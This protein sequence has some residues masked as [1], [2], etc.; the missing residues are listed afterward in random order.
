[1][2]DKELN[3]E[4]Q[5]DEFKADGENSIVAD[6]TNVSPKKRKADKMMPGDKAT[7]KLADNT[8]GTRLGMIN[9]MMNKL[10]NTPKGQL[11]DMYASMFKEEAVEEDEKLALTA[12]DVKEVFGDDLS[13]EA[14]D[15]AVTIFEAA[16]SAKLSE[17]RVRLEEELQAKFDEELEE[18][19]AEVI[20]KVDDYITYCAEQWMEKNEV[21]IESTL[22][23]EIAED[24]MGKLKTLFTESYIDVPEERL[25]LFAEASAKAEELEAKLNEQMAENLEMKKQIEEAQKKEVFAEAAEGLTDT[26]VEKFAALTENVSHSDLE[27]YA[28]KLGVIKE[29]YFKTEKKTAIDI[30]D[31]E[32]AIEEAEVAPAGPMAA[33]AQALARTVKR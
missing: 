16:V 17:E 24:F 11:Q 8:P 9:A 15:R 18:A 25:D 23:T 32:E 3:H 4:E 1:M 7:P 10:S 26:Q 30:S 21:A 6:P 2:S 13:E 14:M 22:R 27:D 12:E 19:V 20:T 5:L 29:N 28:K 33:Y 31:N